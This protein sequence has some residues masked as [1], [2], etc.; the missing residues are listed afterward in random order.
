[1]TPEFREITFACFLRY[2]KKRIL[3]YKLSQY[4]IIRSEYITYRRVS[5]RTLYRVYQN[6]WSDFEV[7]YIHKYGEQNYKS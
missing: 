7:D 2:K 4:C 6:D 3:E 5:I 1:M